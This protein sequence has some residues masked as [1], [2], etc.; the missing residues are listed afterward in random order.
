MLNSTSSFRPWNRVR[1]T[2]CGEAWEPLFF[3]SSCSCIRLLFFFSLFLL[4]KF[5][6]LC[7]ASKKKK[8]KEKEENP[9]TARHIIK[10]KTT[11][12]EFFTQGTKREQESTK[13]WGG[14]G[15]GCKR[16]KKTPVWLTSA[17][18]AARATG[19]A[20]DPPQPPTL[21]FLLLLGKS[22]TLN[23]QAP[24]APLLRSAL[25]VDTGSHSDKLFF[26]F[27]YVRVW[28]PRRQAS[29]LRRQERGGKKA[30]PGSEAETRPGVTQTEEGG[31][32]AGV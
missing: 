31:R 7:N 21:F 3:F 10:P 25:H 26:I 13:G 9:T 5:W 18:A 8:E 19:P 23:C 32:G 20:V 4:W 1:N 6:L 14:V 15:W 11:R 27:Y 16:K 30:V 24:I 17:A 22:L 28:P 2:S 12:Y 29:A